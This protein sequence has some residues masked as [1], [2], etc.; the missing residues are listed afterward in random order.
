[1]ETKTKRNAALLAVSLFSLTWLSGIWA[2]A[3]ANPHQS[4]LNP[5]I[6]EL[7]EMAT[8]SSDLETLEA[9]SKTLE[10]KV[11]ETSDEVNRLIGALD[12]SRWEIQR[13]AAVALGNGKAKQAVPSLV[14]KLEKL[15]ATRPTAHNEEEI[16]IANQHAFVAE[17]VVVA[18]S[19][20][21]DER[22]IEPLLRHP[23]FYTL[24]MGTMPL[25]SFGAKALPAMLGIAADRNGLRYKPILGVI[26][27]IRDPEA[28]PLL[29]ETAGHRYVEIRRS[30]VSALRGMKAKE[31]TSTFEQLLND[32]DDS[33]RFSVFQALIE[34][35]PQKYAMKALR[36][37]KERIDPRPSRRYAGQVR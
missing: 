37:L 34:M 3:G 20:T 26:A 10:V 28:T 31:A 15:M 6:R 25:A 23:E 12:H 13:A 21:K 36:F 27:N 30:A 14:Q 7:L 8:P 35:E 18:L 5:S 32:R 29:L 24:H 2:C 17:A 22:A 4:A 16:R 1:M 33:I 11:P 19:L 9:L